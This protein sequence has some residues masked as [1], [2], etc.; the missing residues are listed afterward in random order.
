MKIK[1]TDTM[2]KIITVSEL[3]QVKR[4]IADMKEDTGLDDYARTA[5]RIAVGNYGNEILKVEAEIAKNGRV[6]NRYADESGDLDVWLKV[7]AFNTFYGF[8]TI[9]A[10]LSDIWEASAD[11]N[12]GRNNYD[13]LRGY[14]YIR[15]FK[16]VK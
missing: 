12:S 9:G 15:E 13:E 7:Y 8:Y 6:W 14:M 1:F 4:I 10:Y 3:P 2:K 5:A 16:E 11:I